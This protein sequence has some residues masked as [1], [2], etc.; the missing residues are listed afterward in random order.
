MSRKIN[1]VRAE[2]LSDEKRKEF[3]LPPSGTVAL[4]VSVN[5]PVQR[6]YEKIPKTG[7]FGFL[8]EKVKDTKVTTT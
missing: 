8:K 5:S 1:Y 4:V 3:D 2:N 7:F 6:I